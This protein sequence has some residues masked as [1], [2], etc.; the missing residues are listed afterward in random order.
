MACSQLPILRTLRPSLPPAASHSRPPS[1]GSAVPALCRRRTRRPAAA[2]D[3]P[4][5]PAGVCG[6][7]PRLA[8]ALP[9]PRAAGVWS[10]GQEQPV[11]G[12]CAGGE[13]RLEVRLCQ[14]PAK[15]AAMGGKAPTWL[16]VVTCYQPAALRRCLPRSSEPGD[17]TIRRC[18]SVSKGQQ[19]LAD[20]VASIPAL[21]R[22]R[23][24][25]HHLYCFNNSRPHCL[26][27]VQSSI[28]LT[29]FMLHVGKRINTRR[30]RASSRACRQCSN[31]WHGKANTHDC[32]A[33]V[34]RAHASELCSCAGP[35]GWHTRHS[36]YLR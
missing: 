4:V 32:A 16:S 17:V 10:A 23:S 35:P 25:L 18:Y 34:G 6:A 13:V 1:A 8:A 22:A 15:A 5:L 9:L 26:T 20:H 3:V 7:A 30:H 29:D 36:Q 11:E 12:G 14:P 2:H 33:G 28:R 21:L 19:Q 27:S 31:R 24:T